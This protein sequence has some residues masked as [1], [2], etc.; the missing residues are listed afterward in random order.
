MGDG[1]QLPVHEIRVM[2][3]GADDVGLIGSL[4]I[5]AINMDELL[6]FDPVTELATAPC[7]ADLDGDGVLD[8]FDFLAF[9]NFFDAGDPRADFDGDGV[10]DIFD[11]LAFG[12]EFDAGCP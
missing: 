11:F 8:I 3:E 2:A 5:N 9:G 4:E 10:L 12:N 6:L 7:R 1:S